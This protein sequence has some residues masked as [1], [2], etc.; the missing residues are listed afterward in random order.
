M[1]RA[2]FILVLVLCFTVGLALT[3][4]LGTCPTARCDVRGCSRVGGRYL[5]LRDLG[6]QGQGRSGLGLHA[7]HSIF[8]QMLA[9]VFGNL[10]KLLLAWTALTQLSLAADWCTACVCN[11]LDLIA[12][13]LQRHPVDIRRLPFT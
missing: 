2:I 8:H 11:L 7:L 3:L 6:L 1:E 13:L 9:G 4:T 10:T 5:V 12:M